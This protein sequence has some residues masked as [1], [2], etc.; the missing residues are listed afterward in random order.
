MNKT[1]LLWVGGVIL[2]VI[3]SVLVF[4]DRTPKGASE[5][6][7]KIGYVKVVGSLPVHIAYDKEFF[8]KRGLK[9][10]KVELS[11]ANQVIEALSR[12]DIDV[13]SFISVFPLFSAE[14][15]APGKMQIF[16]VSDMTSEHPF[17]AVM[18]LNESSV[19]D[20]K[21]LSAKKIGVF[22]GSTGSNFL[23]AYLIG[24][25][26]DVSK[27]EYVQL[28]P[29]T[30]LT[31]LYAKSIDAL[32]SYEPTV[33]TALESGKVRKIT[34]SVYAEQFNHSPIASHIIATKF[35]DEYPEL[36]EEVVS[37]FD[38]AN[39]YISNNDSEV[40]AFITSFY[41]LPKNVADKVSLTKMSNYAD[42]DKNSF[43]EFVDYIV[44]LGELK[45]K[46]DISNI[47]YQK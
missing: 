30:Q 14:L 6:T 39:A 25:G 47:Y 33:T 17:D 2:L 32:F 13:A 44:T 10:E 37:S 46:P 38:E 43:N 4:G 27:I 36:A 41:G 16:S 26:V 40:R 1:V 42:L 18:V 23:K 11:S 29:P 8:T 9:V 34:G 24:K 31:A 15:V 22:P 28:A 5:K 12:G 21:D 7:I 45:S 19:K 3:A 35:V 20:V